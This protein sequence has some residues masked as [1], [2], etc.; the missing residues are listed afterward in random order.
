MGF[1]IGRSASH[2]LSRRD[3]LRLAALGVGT[4]ALRP[5]GAAGLAEF[6][7]G[8][9]LGRVTTGKM[10]IFAHPD[11]GSR[12]VGTL[13]GDSVIRWMREVAGAMPG[14]INQRFVETPD[15]FVWGGYVQPVWNLPNAPLITVPQT[16]LGS[17]MWVEVSVPYVELT[18]DNPPPRAPWLRYQ[19]SIQL[20]PRFYY[21]QI[22]W[23]DGIRIDESGQ[24]WYRLNEK[25]GSGDLFWGRAEAFRP[26]TT[27]ELSPLAGGVQR[28]SIVIG[29]AEQTLSCLEGDEEVYFARISSGAIYNAGGER[30]S[31]WAT[32]TGEFPIWRKAISL[33]LSGGS[34]AAGWNL[35]AVGW[36]SLFVGTGVAIHATYW[37]NNYGEPS[38]RGCVNASPDDAK[39]VFRWTLPQVPYV[40]GDTTV[41][42][43]GGTTVRVED[44]GGGKPGT[45]SMGTLQ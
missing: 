40:P 3:F 18:L 14:R 32:P 13:Y 26:L 2:L 20:P 23:V 28:K 9:K 24:V 8:E 38:S 30:V 37:H 1:E 17:G 21:S 4:L 16:S 35:P 22:V 10:D 44:R 42:M 45:A 36:V 7:Q 11:A 31:A 5:L 12:V 41:G 39:W 15:G 29:L 6:P 19:L 27:E 33:P 25:Y 34:A 43:P